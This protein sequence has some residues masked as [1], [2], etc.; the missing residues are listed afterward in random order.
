MLQAVKEH[1]R[2]LLQGVAALWVIE[3]CNVLLGH[4]LSRWGIVPRTMWGL[5][6]IPLSPF[7]HGSVVHLLLN[8][9]PLTLLGG[10]VMMQGKARFLEVSLC[11]TMLGGAGVWLFGRAA[12]HVGASGLIFGYFGYLVARGWY[13][14]DLYALSAAALTVLFYGGMLWGIVPTRLGVSWEAHLFG[15]LA[16]I[17]AARL[18]GPAN[19]DAA[20]ERQRNNIAIR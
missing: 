14:R 4:R 8:T 11:I 12:S 18:Q 16:G 6:G 2:F 19:E 7:L 5:V 10:L 17:V 20:G 15:L 3:L 13:R 1:T 9:L